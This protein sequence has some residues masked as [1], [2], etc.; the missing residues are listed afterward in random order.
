M[1]PVAN[2]NATVVSGNGY[3]VRM[4][5]GPSTTYAVLR[6]WPV[7]TR[8]IILAEGQNWCRISVG[9]N[10]GYMMTQ[11]LRKDGS[12]VPSYD[13]DATVW[14]ANGKGVRLRNRPSTNYAII[15]VYS[16]GT[17]VKI[18]ERPTGWYRIQIGSRVG[19]MMSQF[20]IENA[21]YKVNGVTINNMNPVVGNILAIQSV[22][23]SQRRHHLSVAAHRH[24]RQGIRGGQQRLLRCDRAGCGLHLPAAGRRLR[25]LD[26]LRGQRLHRRCHQPSAAGGRE[27]QS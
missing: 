16:V 13:G 2:T 12:P 22:D 5:S 14:A 15:G 25:P 10:V 19:Y 4:R 6:K 11:F 23:P 21:S 7:G 8:A 1:T 20:L 17:Q 9:G 24:Q 18:L 26:R 27:V 3:G